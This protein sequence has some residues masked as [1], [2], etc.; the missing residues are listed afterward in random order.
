V[1]YPEEDYGDGPEEPQ[2]FDL[3]EVNPRLA[4]DE[5]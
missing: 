2:P 3:D 5:D 4:E 1:E